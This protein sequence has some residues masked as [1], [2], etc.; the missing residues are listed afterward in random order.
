[1]NSIN[2]EYD[3]AVD[4]AYFQITDQLG[5]DSEEIADGII[6]DYDQNDNVIAVELLG[7]KTINPNDFQKLKPLLSP[8]ALAQFQEWLPRLA[9]AG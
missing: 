4:A 7:V 2:I 5:I 3:P 8:S 9:I 1:M 6:V